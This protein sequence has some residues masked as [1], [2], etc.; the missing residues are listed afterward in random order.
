MSHPY[1]KRSC[2][3][4]EPPTSKQMQQP[5]PGCFNIKALSV[6]PTVGHVKLHKRKWLCNVTQPNT[7]LRPTPFAQPFN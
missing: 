1:P 6:C 5:V 2:I 3:L 7:H 4:T